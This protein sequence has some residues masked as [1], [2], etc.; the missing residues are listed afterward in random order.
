MVPQNIRRHVRALPPPLP[1]KTVRRCVTSKTRMLPV[2]HRY[3]GV[4]ERGQ[5]LLSI[6]SFPL[7]VGIGIGRL[8]TKHSK[9]AHVPPAPSG[10]RHQARFRRTQWPRPPPPSRVR[11]ASWPPKPGARRRK[12]QR[13]APAGM[14]VCCSGKGARTLREEDDACDRGSASPGRSVVFRAA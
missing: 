12:H 14:W 9:R 1:K 8:S 5:L 11:Q 6:L 3:I 4:R 10:D 2:A 7:F 13:S